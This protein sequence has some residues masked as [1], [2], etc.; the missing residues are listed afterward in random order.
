MPQNIN[1]YVVNVLPKDPTVP[2]T[3]VADIIA[4]GTDTTIE[5]PSQYRAIAISVAIKNQDTVNAC[6]FSVNGQPLVALSA[7]ADQ[8]IN[9]QNIVRVRIVACEAGAVHV[10]SQVTPM[11]YNTEAQRFRTVSQ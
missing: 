1:G 7:G 3:F 5:Y 11:Y 8:N 2:S 6:Q 4:A 9:D 10:L